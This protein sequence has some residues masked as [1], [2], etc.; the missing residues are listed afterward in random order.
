MALAISRIINF[1][2][3][4]HLMSD[5]IWPQCLMF[6]LCDLPLWGL[7]FYDPRHS[8]L[9][10]P[11]TSKEIAKLRQTLETI[12]SIAMQNKGRSVDAGI[13]SLGF[14]RKN[15]HMEWHKIPEKQS[16]QV[17][18]SNPA[19][20]KTYL[21]E[22]WRLALLHLICNYLASKDSSSVVLGIDSILMPSL[23]AH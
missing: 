6:V 17:E 4:P 18:N 3:I 15:T 11:Q 23:G 12:Q 14:K 16:K 8:C 1:I 22:L 13:T 20:M 7:A 19:A 9:T 10:L 5:Y 21:E 2:E